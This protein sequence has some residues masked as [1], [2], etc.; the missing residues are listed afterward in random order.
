MNSNLE[1]QAENFAKRRKFVKINFSV[2]DK[3]FLLKKEAKRE[4]RIE[5]LINQIM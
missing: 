2:G 3:F 4:T 1:S 5:R